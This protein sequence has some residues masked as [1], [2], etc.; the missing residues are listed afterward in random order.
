V[1]SRPTSAELGRACLWLCLPAEG[2]VRSLGGR[3]GPSVAARPW[4][5]Q[6]RGSRRDG[7]VYYPVDGNVFFWGGNVLYLAQEGWGKWWRCVQGGMHACL[8]G[9]SAH[10]VRREG[11]RNYFIKK[12][13][14][15]NEVHMCRTNDG[16]YVHTYRLDKCYYNSLY[17]RPIV[18]SFST[19]CCCC[20]LLCIICSEFKVHSSRNQAGEK[21][22]Q[23]LLSFFFAF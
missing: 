18:S 22:R 23:T 20:C 5:A 12:I 13:D 1:A 6:R 7:G 16:Y 3:R 11:I 9:Q 2:A 14:L 15:K 4:Q 8:D 19:C 17:S 10:R 21:I